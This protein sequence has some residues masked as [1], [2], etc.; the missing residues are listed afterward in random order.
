MSL[1]RSFGFDTVEVKDSQSLIAAL[2][3]PQTSKRMIIIRTDPEQNVV[4]LRGFFDA[5]K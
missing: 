2:K 3:A 1:G 5:L 4:T